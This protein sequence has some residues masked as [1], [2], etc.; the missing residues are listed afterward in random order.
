MGRRSRKR[1]TAPASRREP[2][3][4]PAPEAA[5]ARR[6]RG[7]RPVAPWG[8]FPLV[9][10][11]VLLAL[12]IGVAGF[13]TGG[14]QGG[15]MLAAAAALGS[16]AGLELAIRE[17]FGGFRSHTVLLAAAP[18]VLAMGVLF[19]AGA[20]RVAMLGAGIGVFAAAFWALREVFKRRSGG[21]G[22]R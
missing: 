4:A 13:A 11:C 2:A 20:P 17:H 6:R 15:I 10:V 22:F 1:A 8:R 21:Y 9:E 12:V 5:P 14:D 18:G 3:R 19:F 7:E 16:L